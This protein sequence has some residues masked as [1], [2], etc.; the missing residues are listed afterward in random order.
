MSVSRRDAYLGALGVTQWRR[1]D[2]LHTTIEGT[3]AIAESTKAIPVEHVADT[4][5]ASATVAPDWNNKL[6]EAVDLDALKAQVS[7]CR[8]C[9]LADSRTQTVF[10]VGSSN[11]RLLVIGE[12]PGV[13]ED[14]RGEPFVGNAGKLLDNM[15]RAIGLSREQVFIANVIKC[16]PPRNRNPH[17]QEIAA[18]RGFLESQIELLNPAVLLSVGAVSAHSLLEVDT[19]VGKL[20]GKTYR[21]GERQIP[22]LVTYHPAYLLRKPQEKAKAWVDLQRLM[23]LLQ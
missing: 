23:A 12:A 3:A 21:F 1:R 15:L 8:A 19:P 10:G 13:E 20:R 6:P 17:A 2:M 14:K 11:P 9:E 18:C 22:L 16:R 7:T 5:A 4:S